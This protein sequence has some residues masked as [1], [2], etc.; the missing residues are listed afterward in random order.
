MLNPAQSNNSDSDNTPKG[1]S[2]HGAQSSEEPSDNNSWQAVHLP[3]TLAADQCLGP[4]PHLRTN[5]MDSS[6]T[7]ET[8]ATSSV[9]TSPTEQP[10][11]RET[12]LLNLVRDLNDCNDVLL[13]KVSQLE[14]SLER[15]QVALQSEIDRS[16]PASDRE[17]VQLVTEL[18]QSTQA[19]Q[20]QQRQ[21]ETMQTELTTL[22]ERAAQLETDHAVLLQQHTTQ[23]QE[24]L[25]ANTNCRDL[26]A[27]L[28]RQQRYTLQF[29]AALEKCLSMST[30]A[31]NSSGLDT[32]GISMPTVEQI[33]P[34]ESIAGQSKLDP[35]LESIIRGPQSNVQSAPVSPSEAEAEDQ[36]WYDLARVMGPAEAPLKDNLQE[37]SGKTLAEEGSSAKLSEPSTST[38]PSQFSEPSPRANKVTSDS[39]DS[40]PSAAAP[41]NVDKGLSQLSPEASEIL[42]KVQSA[43]AAA[44]AD[45][46]LPAMAVQGSPSPLVNPLKPQ[47]KIG[48]LAAID[49]PNF[50]RLKKQSSQPKA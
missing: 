40:N 7:Y 21:N 13:A 9:N 29:K 26:R 23:S 10:S 12:E 37:L 31:S 43:R 6:S 38:E 8:N 20:Q 3:G 44:A 5:A 18:E 35:Q 48:S 4:T 32:P 11:Q 2:S 39:D 36:L 34:W 50:P 1:I 47:K 41:D 22:R 19:L 16:S 14:E 30:E 27:R 15:S 49:L 46:Y 42:A 33:R 24:L 45:T 25:Q 17:I 28:Q